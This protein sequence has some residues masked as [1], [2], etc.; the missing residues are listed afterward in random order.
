MFLQPGSFNTYHHARLCQLRLKIQ[1]IA[2]QSFRPDIMYSELVSN[3]SL[4]PLL[5]VTPVS[6]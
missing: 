5:L 6:A 2:N 3:L 1:Y 4:I